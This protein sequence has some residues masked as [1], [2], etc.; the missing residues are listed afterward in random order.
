MFSIA[1]SRYSFLLQIAF[2][3]LNGLGLFF[4]IVYNVNTPDLY[5]NN[6]H[7]PMGWVFT[8]LSLAWI[9]LSVINS[10]TRI[11]SAHLHFGQRSPPYERLPETEDS[12]ETRWSGDTNIR[13]ERRGSAITDSGTP[14]SEHT[15]V[16]YN[17]DLS[18]YYKDSMTES[19]GRPGLLRDSRL[20]RLLSQNLQR[21]GKTKAGLLI[22]IVHGLLERTL[23]IQGFTVL[24]TGIVT[25]G[26]IFVSSISSSMR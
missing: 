22:R 11:S 21:V 10:Y 9:C 20:D 13:S 17:D 18:A 15:A 14:T 4:G 3:V 24:L 5:E 6:S 16:N 1:R 23:V 8:W 2:F 7:H 25:Y 12:A 19:D 26:G